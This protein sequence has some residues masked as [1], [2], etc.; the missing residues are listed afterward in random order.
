MA[1]VADGLNAILRADLPDLNARLY[2][3][4]LRPTVPDPIEVPPRPSR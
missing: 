4:E 1:D 3:P 2:A